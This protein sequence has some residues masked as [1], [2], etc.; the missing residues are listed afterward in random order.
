M[1]TE[2]SLPRFGLTR[3]G[4]LA[5]SAG[6]AAVTA[7]PAVLRTG[8][9]PGA[10]A[11]TVQRR[12][13]Y[14]ALVEAVALLPMN[15]VDARRSEWA[16]D[17]LAELY[18]NADRNRRRVLDEMVDS[19]AAPG[20]EASFLGLSPRAR[21]TYLKRRLGGTRPNTILASALDL[22]ARPFREHHTELRVAWTFAYAEGV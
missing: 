18:A 16:T 17:Q 8:A 21:L 2:H 12:A 19:V 11:L 10:P 1:N 5:A 13:V 3:R 9:A 15:S 7:L 4:F 20:G 22:A 14:A 6:A